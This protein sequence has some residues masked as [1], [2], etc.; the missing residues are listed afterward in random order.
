MPSYNGA[1]FD[2]GSIVQNLTGFIKAF[3]FI[4]LVVACFALG[5][6]STCAGAMNETQATIAH[7]LGAVV[8]LVV[9]L[10]SVIYTYD[11]WN[12]VVYFSEEVR[13]PERNI[14]RSLFGGVLSVIAIYLLFNLALLYVLPLSQIAGNKLAIGTAAQVNLRSL[15]RH[16]YQ[17][18][19]HHLHVQRH[20]RLSPDVYAACCIP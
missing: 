9:A 10:Q 3:A 8:A 13:E 11:G 1:G 6:Q 4:A 16:D 2:W 19:D 14:P 17:V 18:A 7:G 15:W 5:G 12:G 20:Q